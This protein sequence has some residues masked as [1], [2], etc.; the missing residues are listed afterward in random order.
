MPSNP[1]NIQKL[2]S[3]GRKFASFARASLS[4]WHTV[5]YNDIHRSVQY[6]VWFLSAVRPLWHCNG[7][8]V[9]TQRGRYRSATAALS[10]PREAL[11]G[12]RQPHL[13]QK[14]ELRCQ[15]FGFAPFYSTRFWSVK[16]LLFSL[17]IIQPVDRTVHEVW[18][19]WQIRSARSQ[20]SR[21]DCRRQSDQP[22]RPL[23]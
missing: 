7:A 12:R 16:F 14:T 10:Q 13:S 8:P 5:F 21:N 3:F 6:F 4:S 1:C 22:D 9:A 20:H 15:D 19:I 17:T 18:R 2:K 11:L 23:L